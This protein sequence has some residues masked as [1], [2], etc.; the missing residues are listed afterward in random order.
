MSKSTLH[1]ILQMLT[2]SECMLNISVIAEI[3]SAASA[4]LLLSSVCYA[5]TAVKKKCHAV[6]IRSVIKFQKIP[7]PLSHVHES[8]ICFSSTSTTLFIIPA[9]FAISLFPSIKMQFFCIDSNF[10]ICLP[11]NVIFLSV[12]HPFW[13]KALL[14]MCTCI[15]FMTRSIIPICPAATWMSAVVKKREGEGI[16][17]SYLS[18]QKNFLQVCYALLSCIWVLRIPFRRSLHLSCELVL[19]SGLPWLSPVSQILPLCH[20]Q[21]KVIYCNVFC[22][23]VC[24]LAC[25]TYWNNVPKRSATFFAHIR[26][27]DVLVQPF[28][29]CFYDTYSS[30][31]F[32][33]IVW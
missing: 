8:A 7:Q 26:V 14:S 4:M 23:F 6:W 29:H 1:P 28:H 12:S 5:G 2:F 9:F 33:V 11:L 17:N 27:F 24:L 31:K 21:W 3:T 22:L 25:F 30:S 15:I 19:P 16:I 32:L 10:F 20:L 13:H 18:M